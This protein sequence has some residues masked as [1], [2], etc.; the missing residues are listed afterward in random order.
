MEKKIYEPDL[1]SFHFALLRT[2]DPGNIGSAL[3]ALINMGFHNM[4]VIEPM[5]FNEDAVK[6]LAAGAKE[7]VDALIMS[8]TLKQ[9]AEH[10]DCIYAFSARGRYDRPH[11]S[12][13]EM[14]NELKTNPF[15]RVLFL[16]GNETNG[17]NNDELHYAQ[18]T[19]YIPTAPEKP[20]LNL[21]QAVMLAAYQIRQT[22]SE[23][24]ISVH[25]GVAVSD[26]EQ[27]FECFYAILKKLFFLKELNAPKTRLRLFNAFKKW[28][29]NNSEYAVISNVF[30]KM[31]ERLKEDKD[32]HF[33]E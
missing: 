14:C 30:K 12:M 25:K 3:R 7:H 21:S 32:R 17:L 20:S 8:K 9:A 13:L 29:L 2:F 10:V 22:F 6:K 11:I 4:W 23:T 16:F 18:K 28:P 19:V 24:T 15:E 26:K 33:K 31:E 5:N 1:S 27:L